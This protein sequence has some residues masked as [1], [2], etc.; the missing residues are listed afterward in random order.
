MQADLCQSECYTNSHGT[1]PVWTGAVATTLIENKP[2]E[3]VHSTSRCP[4]PCAYAR[5]CLSDSYSPSQSEAAG[6][7]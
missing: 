3:V 5:G 7:C 1:A 4:S 2:A 6:G